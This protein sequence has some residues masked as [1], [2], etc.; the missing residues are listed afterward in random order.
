[1]NHATAQSNV[2][3]HCVVTQAVLSRLRSS[4]YREL[5]SVTCEFRSGQLYLAGQVP[6][7]YMKQ[8]AQETIRA[9]DGVEQI[10]NRVI[11]ICHSK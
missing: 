10:V 5:R 7:Y 4:R 3:V 9:I 1:M 2:G 11:V 6:T 8:M